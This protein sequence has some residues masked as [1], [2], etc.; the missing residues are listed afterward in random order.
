VFARK[1]IIYGIK[2]WK[3][4]LFPILSL[5]LYVKNCCNVEYMNWR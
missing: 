1:D 2:K 5:F 3:K 4:Q